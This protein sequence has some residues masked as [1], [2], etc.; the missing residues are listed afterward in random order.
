M[1]FEELG[2]AIFLHNC[3]N[4]CT[5]EQFQIQFIVIDQSVFST[6][7]VILLFFLLQGRTFASLI[8]EFVNVFKPLNEAF[9]PLYNSPEGR[10]KKIH[11]QSRLNHIWIILE[12]VYN[13]TLDVVKQN[14]PQYV[15]E[16]QGIA[17]GSQ[18]EFYKVKY[19]CN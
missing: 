4:S 18:V 3:R 9:I 13:E 17:D 14:F 6:L 2:R 7:Y 5:S 8:R 10:K 19:T 11:I 15:R 16:L 1:S 12:R